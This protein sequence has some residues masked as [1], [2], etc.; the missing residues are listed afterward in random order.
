MMRDVLVIVRR[1]RDGLVGRYLRSDRMSIVENGPG[2][3]GDGFQ[4]FKNS[5]GSTIHSVLL[6]R[7][8]WLKQKSVMDD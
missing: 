8:T 1:A 5:F 4:V 6:V 3:R 2:Y 7:I